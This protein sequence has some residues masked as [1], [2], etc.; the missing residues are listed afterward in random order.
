MIIRHPHPVGPYCCEHRPVW[1]AL[2]A[3]EGVERGS[4]GVSRSTRR[5]VTWPNA[6]YTPGRL[7]GHVTSSQAR[8]IRRWSQASPE[9][10]PGVSPS[11]QEG[12]SDLVSYPDRA[13]EHGR[14]GLPA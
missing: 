1:A 4:A 2:M 12:Q 3:D 9:A 8:R 5:V 6:L 11:H 7:T 13:T 10:S 14:Q